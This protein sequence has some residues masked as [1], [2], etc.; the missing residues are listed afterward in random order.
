M[1]KLD[2][3]IDNIG[4]NQALSERYL[5]Y[6]LSTIMSRSLPD[7]RDGLKPV[8]RRL[9]YAMRQL[10]LNPTN[11]FKKCARVVGDVIGKYHPHGDV[12]VYET[13]VRLA[14]EFTVRYPLI[15]GQGNFGSIDGDNAAAMRYTE[16]RLSEVAM[17]LLKELDDDTVDF[18][19][20]YDDQ[21]SEPTLLPAA[22][23]NLLANG[24]EGIAVGMATSVPPH[25]LHELSD[26]LLYLVK[27]PEA[28]CAD[29][30]KFV[31]GPD[32][33]TGGIIVENPSTIQT[34]YEAGRGSFR[35]RAKWHREN[36]NHGLYQ[37]IITE[38]PYQVQKSKLIEKIADLFKEKKLT[39]LGNVRDESAEDI[40]II[41]EPKN[42][43]ASEDM[44]M[45]VLFKLTDLEIRYNLNLN[46][47]DSDCIP[48]VMNLKEVLVAFLDHRHKVVLR[49]SNYRLNKINDRLEILDGL[50]IAY[51][52]LDEIIKII[53][54]ED[55]PK[56]EL[57]TRFKLTSNQADAILNM[58]LRSLRL[59]EEMVIRKERDQLLIDKEKLELIISDNGTCQ[60]VITDEIKEIQKKFGYSNPLGTRRTEISGA[61]PVTNLISAEDFI[62]KEAVTILSSKMGWIRAIKGHSDDISDTKYKEGDEEKFIIKAHTTDKLI[63]FSEKGKFYTILVDKIARGKGQGDPIRLLIDLE[64]D[65]EII[66]MFIAGDNRNLLLASK[67]GKGFIVSEQD[68]IASTKTGKQ[69]LN[70]SSKDKAFLCKIVDGDALAIIGDNRKL[71]I[72]KVDELPVMKKGQGVALQKYKEAMVSDIKI[73]NLAEGL[74]WSLGNKTRLET[75]LI[76]WLGKRASVGKL[77]PVGFP[78]NNKFDL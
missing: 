17:L 29:L 63:I 50:I 21:E 37:I 22:F 49:R 38:I 14:Q 18:K 11:G 36:L 47:L 53:R 44:I 72:F 9:L 20:T 12:A 2:E 28:S 43:T 70:L 66:T 45:E 4:F 30:L 61:A 62:E 27:H 68:V 59:L 40:R 25:N 69:I 46:V 26:A 51:V 52:N 57:I 71:L 7:V 6:A 60:K 19:L 64:N 5:A 16:S 24:S 42:R 41:L 73:F 67:S 58:R 77:P 15:Q 32:F 39:M 55:E 23:P 10:N 13:L 78:K 31:P 34:A 56:E 75:E 35:L 33:P 74:S 1:K 54:E 3:K 65:D 8:H 48:R 76:G